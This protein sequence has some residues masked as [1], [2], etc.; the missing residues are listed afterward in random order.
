MTQMLE[1]LFSHIQ[2]SHTGSLGDHSRGGYQTLLD[3]ELYDT[4]D[5]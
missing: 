3:N 2:N 5:Y 4:T 1:H